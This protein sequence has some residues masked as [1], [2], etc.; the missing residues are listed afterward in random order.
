M[1]VLL[2]RA[3]AS[4]GKVATEYGLDVLLFFTIPSRSLG[5][6]QPSI[7]W[8]PTLF[9]LEQSGL[10]VK[11][12]T[13]I[14]LVPRSS[15]VKLHLHSSRSLHGVIRHRNHFTFSP[16]ILTFSWPGTCKPSR[17]VYHSVILRMKQIE[18]RS[19]FNTNQFR[20]YKDICFISVCS[21]SRLC[22][23]YC[24]NPWIGN[25]NGQ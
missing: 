16:K 9:S 3:F 4:P 6:T 22:L 11:L 14:H 12:T 20:V 15:M 21:L 23:G 2:L 17:A 13:H 10:I 8:V 24:V 5:P 19:L 18:I 25:V 1:G 7:Q